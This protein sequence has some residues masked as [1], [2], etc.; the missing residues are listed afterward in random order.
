M[1]LSESLTNLIFFPSI[2]PL[3]STTHTKSIAECVFFCCFLNEE[4]AKI[5]GML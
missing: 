3:T 2:L 1:N 5:T 4:M